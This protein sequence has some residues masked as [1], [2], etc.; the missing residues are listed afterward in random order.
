MIKELN[1]YNHEYDVNKY[2]LYQSGEYGV[3]KIEYHEADK[4]DPTHYID[5]IYSDQVQRIFKLRNVFIP[6]VNNN[7]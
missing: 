5:I 7:N 3:V 2:V 4:E 1:D 6:Q